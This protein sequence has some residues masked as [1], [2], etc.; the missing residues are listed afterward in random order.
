MEF[1]Q[2]IRE[3]IEKNPGVLDLIQF[4][5][6]DHFHM[7]GHVNKQNM[8]LGAPQQPRE[9]IQRPLS[10]EKVTVWCAL[11]K[12]DIEM[13]RRKFFLA[14]MRRRGVDINNVVFQQDGAPPHCSNRTIQYL[15]QY[16]PGDSLISRRADNFIR[17]I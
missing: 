11:G 12:R 8:W 9:Y 4:S 15:R 16:F 7:R 3:I 14:L 6:E 2:I 10:Q 17:H 5:D 13:M 1:S